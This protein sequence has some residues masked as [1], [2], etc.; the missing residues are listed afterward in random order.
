MS[1]SRDGQAFEKTLSEIDRSEI[2]DQC[3]RVVESSWFRTS[4]RCSTLLRYLVEETIQGRAGQLKERMIAVKAFHRS[5]AYDNNTD[6]IVRIAAGEVRKRLAQYY[7]DPRNSGQIQIELPVGSYVPEFRF[8]QEG[9]PE[10]RLF[11]TELSIHALE[12]RLAPVEPASGEN[13]EPK[14]DLVFKIRIPNKARKWV[15]V[16]VLLLVAW[17]GAWLAVRLTRPVSGFDAFWAPLLSTQ[18]V[19]LISIGDVLIS[20]AEFVPN[21]Q[22]SPIAIPWSLGDKGYK[23]DEGR[24]PSFGNS[25]A[26]ARVAAILGKHN[27]SFDISTQ[28]RTTFDD[29]SRRPVIEIGSFDNDW[30]MRDTNSMRFRFQIDMKREVRSIAD[31]ENPSEQYGVLPFATAM[32]PTFEDYS[33]VARSVDPSTGQPVLV[34]GGITSLGTIAA[35]NFVADSSYLDDFARKAPKGWASKNVEFV[36]VTSIVDGAVGRSSVVTYYLW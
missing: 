36:L 18:R 3:S 35:A 24:L 23:W 30:T 34:L 14:S 8:P 28:S 6:P 12:N 29:L 19:T 10:P 4:V 22:R 9:D 25:L 11:K 13:R 16:I 33:I 2:A 7:G 32:L 21:G 27:K 5:P 31:R 1:D 20:H 26:A 15:S 17:A